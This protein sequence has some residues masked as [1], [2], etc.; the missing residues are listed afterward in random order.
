MAQAGVSANR[1]ELLQIADA[2]AREKS[3]EAFFD[4]VAIPA[5]AMAQ[6]D[7]DRGV[8][9]PHQRAVIAEGFSA[10]L[11]NL[12]EEGTADRRAGG[13]GGIALVPVAGPVPP[14]IIVVIPAE[15]ASQHCCGQMK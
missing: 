2:V 15:S 8:L 1:L 7:T 14:P 9:T 13:S 11:D 3:I 10:L 12:A 5:L 4:A 6:A